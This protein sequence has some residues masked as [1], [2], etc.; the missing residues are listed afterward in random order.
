MLYGTGYEP[1]IIQRSRS[2]ETR[3]KE[4]PN[5]HLSSLDGELITD[6]KLI[7]SEDNKLICITN[8]PRLIPSCIQAKWA[9]SGI[10]NSFNIL[11]K[12]PS[13]FPIDSIEKTVINNPT[14]KR[15]TGHLYF[16]I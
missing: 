5:T 9:V 12:M 8:I 1:S 10:E 7:T 14:I 2:V 6:F 13:K 11:E 16:F 3:S 15:V 4:K